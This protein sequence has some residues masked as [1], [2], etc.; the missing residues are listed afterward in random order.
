MINTKERKIKLTKISQKFRGKYAFFWRAIYTFWGVFPIQWSILILLQCFSLSSLGSR[1]KAPSPR[2]PSCPWPPARPVAIH[3]DYAEVRAAVTT[4]AVRFVAGPQE[5]AFLFLTRHV[6]D[7]L[8]LPPAQRVAQF[9]YAQ[10]W[11]G[12]P[13]TS[14]VAGG[15]EASHPPSLPYRPA[16]EGGFVRK[17][18]LPLTVRRC[19]FGEPGVPRR[20]VP[21]P[22]RHS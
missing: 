7:F 17:D 9:P 2:S 1:G 5:A 4:A 19:C 10:R 3:T 20:A 14:W 8:A 12:T 22:P 18:L 13:E 6:T 11:T 15:G 16:S 21:L